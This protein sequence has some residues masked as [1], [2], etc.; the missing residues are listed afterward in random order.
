MGKNAF[1]FKGH[2]LHCPE[3]IDN[4]KAKARCEAQTNVGGPHFHSRVSKRG[5]EFAFI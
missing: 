5:L 1:G 4:W 2:R 3:S